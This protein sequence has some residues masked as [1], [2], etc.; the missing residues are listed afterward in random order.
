M[1]RPAHPEDPGEGGKVYY[2]CRYCDHY[3]EASR[4]SAEQRRFAEEGAGQRGR[5]PICISCSRIDAIAVPEPEGDAEEPTYPSLTL[6]S[7][8]ATVLA[9]TGEYEGLPELPVEVLRRVFSCVVQRIGP[10]ISDLGDGEFRCTVCARDFP[11]LAAAQQHASTSQR[12]KRAV[13]TA[14]GAPVR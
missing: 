3:H 13:Q 6:E 12:H 11:S 2:F 5:N 10:F 4:F 1:P 14:A 9:F 7:R 8:Y